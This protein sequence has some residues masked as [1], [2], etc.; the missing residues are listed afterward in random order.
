LAV[1]RRPHAWRRRIERLFQFRLV[2]RARQ[3][4]GTDAFA[5]GIAAPTPIQPPLALFFTTGYPG[6]GCDNIGV[7]EYD[8][9]SGEFVEEFAFSVSADKIGV[10]ALGNVYVGY[11]GT[12]IDST[13]KFAIGGNTALANYQPTH[14]SADD[15]L[16]VGP[17]GE[18]VLTGVFGG[19]DT[20]DE[21]DPG[22]SGAASRTFSYPIPPGSPEQQSAAFG[23][24]GTLYPIPVR[25][26]GKG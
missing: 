20:F 10:D 1:A 7:K 18:L 3:A 26:S 2:P 24:D 9:S 15:G 16:V 11:Y 22:T 8:A 4:R 12:N 14:F 21:W 13:E 5:D 25:R 6:C 19:A 17:N 23:A